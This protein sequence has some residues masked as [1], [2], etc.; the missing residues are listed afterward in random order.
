MT[1]F[2]SEQEKV[3]E[4]VRKL[5][6]L[7]KSSNEHE[8]AL[9]LAKAE[10]LLEKYRLDMTSVEMMTGQKEEIIEDSDPL[11]DTERITQWE[12]KLSNG[13]AYLYGCTTIRIGG[14]L[15]KIIGRASDI[16]FVRY[17]VTYITIEFCRMSANIFY[18]KRK[19][20]KD[21]WFLGAT[22]VILERMRQA[23]AQVQ[24]NFANPFAVMTVNN[25]YEEANKKCQEIHPNSRISEVPIPKK[26]SDEAYA[27]GRVAGSK[28][29]LTQDKSLLQQ[30]RPK[31]SE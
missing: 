11:F 6:A 13:I 31:L 9:A 16:L 17:L 15:I 25:R 26:F 5:L 30:N 8:A 23:K 22:E 1:Q 10:D 4:Q 2:S 21:S 3:I 12:S 28:I 24:Q 20:Y 7:S 29:K 14:K 19:D 18:K 27:L